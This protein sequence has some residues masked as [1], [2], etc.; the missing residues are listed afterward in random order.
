MYPST[1]VRFDIAQARIAGLRDQA[2]RESLA[3]AARSTQ[4]R[5]PGRLRFRFVL[6]H[7]AATA[8]S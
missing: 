5:V 7:R 4:Q 1:S 6:R 3:R 8:V 2:R